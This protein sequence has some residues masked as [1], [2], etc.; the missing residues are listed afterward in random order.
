GSGNPP[1]APAPPSPPPPGH[2]KAEPARPG[3]HDEIPGVEFLKGVR[4]IDQEPIGR[5]PRSN[6]VTYVKAFDEIRK[7]F[8]ALPRAK[9]AS[10]SPGAF[11]FNLPARPCDP[12]QRDAFHQ[13]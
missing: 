8:A 13:L 10:L 9:A 11:S 6:P 7:L 5:T 1:L 12:C 2:F 4:L 3:A